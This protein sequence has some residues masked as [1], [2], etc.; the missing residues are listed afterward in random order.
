MFDVSL[1]DPAELRQADD[2]ALAAT[3]ECRTRA[4]AAVA[5]RRLSAIAELTRRRS[6][7]DQRANWACDSWDSAAAEVAAALG[8]SHGKASGQMHLSLTLNR[9]PKLAALFLAGRL[10]AR[11]VS[12]IAW[13]T[14]LVRDE[15]ALRLVDT[16]LAEQ[17]TTWGPL[18]AAKLEK[19]IDASIDR[20]DPGAI[21]RTRA[22]A[23]SRDV[24]IGASD[25]DV[26]TA[27]LWGRLYSTDAAMLDRRLTQMA[28]QVC[29][30]DP[31]TV[32]QRRA[33]ALGAL[34][35]GAE[36][37][38]CGCGS[39]DCPSGTDNDERATGV[40][41]HIV[42]EASTLDAAPDPHQSGKG[43]ASRPVTPDMTFAE[44]LAPDP[45]L[46]PSATSSIKPPVALMTGGG[47]VPAPL[48]AE[49]IRG[50][51]TVRPVRHPGDA[52]PE[53]HYRPSTALAEF[54]R[55]R[56]MTCRFPGCDEPAEFCD[57]DHTVPYPFGP[58]HPSNLKCE[59]RK[60]H[61]L[62]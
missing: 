18:S 7:D 13:R 34:A 11:L 47:V 24:C 20:Y 26:G 41:I 46:D 35:A 42:A 43:P 27:A 3:I 23:R 56:D 40:V 48:L 49:L 6:G 33:D 29:D 51:A 57:V 61:R 22:S 1:P 5:A 9:L 2:A 8:I 17:A 19:A 54:I 25:D 21:R 10:S 15:G 50:G 37:L 44:A 62:A 59:C 38:A 45:E 53:P 16:A 30:D 32:A 14:Y 39:P 12:I 58:T 31:R 55:I 52:P 36:R 4:E 60:H 28:H